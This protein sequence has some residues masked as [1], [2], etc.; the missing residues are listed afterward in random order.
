M[1]LNNKLFSVLRLRRRGLR[2]FTLIEAVISTVII[3]VMFV[4]AMNVLGATAIAKRSTEQQ[5]LGYSL[6]Q[7]LMNEILNQPYE[8]PDQTAE[9]GRES[10]EGGGDRAD[11]DDV[12]DYDTWSATPPEDKNGT[13]LVGYDQW[14]RSVEISFVNP[15]DLRHE[16]ATNTGIKSITVTVSRDGIAATQLIAIRTHAWPMNRKDP[17]IVVLFVVDDTE[18]LTSQ[19]KA[20]QL[21]MKSWGFTVNLIGATESQANL[22]AATVDANVAYISEDI[23]DSDLNTKLRYTLIGVVNEEANL[24]NEFGFAESWTDGNSSNI[25]IV[26][27]SHYI[28]SGLSLGDLQILSSSQPG[29]MLF[30]P[31]APGL[32]TLGRSWDE[33]DELNRRSLA[34][35]EVSSELYGGEF[36][37]GRRVRLPWGLSGFDIGELNKSGRDIMKRSIEWAASK[38]QP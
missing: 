26:D 20:K 14:T 22:D 28:T 21:L 5:A 35:I 13:P 23:D 33:E 19:E 8:D 6:A 4:A 34:V 15:T 1:N 36:A 30:W 24:G 25:Q 38:E 18:S 27:N 9:F 37:T 2:S 11:F 29:H 17:G 16:L 31:Y 10:G 3:G 7:D 32:Q 12:D